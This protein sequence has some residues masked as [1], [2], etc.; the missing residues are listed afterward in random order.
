MHRF[1][2]AMINVLLESARRIKRFSLQNTFMMT[3]TRW[4]Y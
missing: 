1:V 3:T 4:Y 2:D